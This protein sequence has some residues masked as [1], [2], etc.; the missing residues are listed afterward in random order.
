MGMT[1]NVLTDT[2][3]FENYLALYVAIVGYNEKIKD[4]KTGKVRRVRKYP[5]A[6]QA[7]LM[8]G[9]KTNE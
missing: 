6:K 8:M 7:L 5:N 2:V 4:K 1:H 3:G 9:I